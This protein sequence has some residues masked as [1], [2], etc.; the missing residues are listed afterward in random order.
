MHGLQGNSPRGATLGS[1]KTYTVQVG[2]VERELPVMAVAPGVSVA[3][4]NMLGDTEVTE[5]AGRA[6]AERLPAE[7][8]IL[9]TPEVKAVSLAHVISRESGKP[10]IVIRK[11]QKPY[12]HDPLAR[13]VVSITTG[14]PQTLVLD[15]FDVEK[16]RGK[17][18]A[19]VDD[20]VSSGGTLHSITSLLEEV[21]AEVA[22]VVAV[23]TEGQER[24]EV[25][26]LGHLPL[27]KD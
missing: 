26:A 24:P 25:L 4:F 17:R 12:M 15:G 13:E 6:L 5:A 22:A 10:Y 16:L 21:G 23:F 19:I 18:V 20:V 11:T 1:V 3:L 7:V 9:V 14:K 8:D 2:G 27:F